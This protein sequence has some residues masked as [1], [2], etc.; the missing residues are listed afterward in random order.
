MITGW[1]EKSGPEARAPH[2]IVKLKLSHPFDTSKTCEARLMVD[3]G[4]T[5]SIVLAKELIADLGLEFKKC[6]PVTWGNGKPG[7]V[8]VYTAVVDLDGERTEVEIDEVEETP[9]LHTGLLGMQL[10]LNM[11]LTITPRNGVISIKTV[12]TDD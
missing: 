12:Q 11:Q 8:R 2:A 9:I 4:F 1:F 5:G 10:L 3:T 6:R 7:S